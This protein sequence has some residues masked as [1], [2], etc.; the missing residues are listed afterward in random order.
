MPRQGVNWPQATIIFVVVA[1]VGYLALVP[2]GYL[3]WGTFFDDG[4]F[5]LRHF[6]EA[7]GKEGLA[8]TGVTSLLF[9]A[10]STVLAV[11]LGS[12]L[13]YLIV[14]TDA[15]FKALMFTASL[16]PLIMP[17]VLHT[18]AWIFLLAPRTGWLNRLFEPIFGGPILDVFSLSGMILVEGMHLT[19]LVFL[20]MAAAFRSMDPALEESAIMSGARLPTVLRRVTLPVARP[21]FLA[22]LLLMAVHGLESFEVPALLGIPNGTWTFTSRIWI[23]LRGFPREFGAAGAYS[24][25]L[26]VLTSLG[27]YVYM[28]LSR[29]GRAWQTVTGKGFKPRVIALG[30]WRAPATAIALVYL[31]VIVVLPLLMLAYASGRPFFAVPT[32]ETISTMTL[33]NYRHMFDQD[34]TVRA[35]RNSLVLGLS[36]ATIVMIMMAVASWIAVRTKFRWRGVVDDL[37]FLP[38]VIPGLVLGTAL[39]FLYLRHP[40][41]VYGTIWILLIAYITKY[42][43]YGMRFASASMHQIGAELEESAQLSGATWWQTFRR[44]ILPLLAPGLMAGWIYILIVSVRELS[45]SILLYSPGNEVL[46]IR[47]WELWQDG[48]STQLAA[49]GTTLVGALVV[50]SAAA[51]K[52]GARLG[53]GES[54]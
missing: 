36:A 38:L 52:L 54:E 43:P 44:V 13:A 27:L 9:A 19:P 2:L 46:A 3:L 5:T 18:V 8:E 53:I 29:R 49:L 17:G 28:R 35:V 16:I 22:A 12:A 24:V 32:W 10:G 34:G 30:R 39:L 25:A 14:R 40:L 11:T 26:L 47:I 23:S 37:A 20:L 21:A 4:G 42:M 48:R 7:F 51:Y 31:F 41:P 6:D 50:L 1:I 33:D 45:S 15:P